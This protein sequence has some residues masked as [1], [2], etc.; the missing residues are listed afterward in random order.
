LNSDKRSI[1]GRIPTSSRLGIVSQ[2]DR[3]T[4]CSKAETWKYSSTSTV[5]WWRGLESSVVD[6]SV[7]VDMRMRDRSVNQSV[8]IAA[9]K[10]ETREFSVGHR[11]PADRERGG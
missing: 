1:N 9:G 2:F 6:R 11:R 5:K 3:G 4:C 8:G 10:V 7:T